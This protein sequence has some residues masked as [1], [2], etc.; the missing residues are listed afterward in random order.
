MDEDCGGQ[1]RKEDNLPLR[2]SSER[3]LNAVSH[4]LLELEE[5][6]QSSN[7]TSKEI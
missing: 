6:I 4:E 2:L 3:Q 1:Q 5:L 7:F